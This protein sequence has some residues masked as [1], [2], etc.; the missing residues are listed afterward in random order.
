MGSAPCPVLGSGLRWV[1]WL[2][3]WLSVKTEVA[4]LPFSLRLL[5][6][7]GRRAM[8]IKNY[9]LHENDKAKREETDRVCPQPNPF[10]LSTFDLNS[11]RNMG[12]AALGRY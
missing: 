5:H 2:V 1:S 6:L 11:S 9:N 4:S 8:L 3:G 10:C 12:S 7:G